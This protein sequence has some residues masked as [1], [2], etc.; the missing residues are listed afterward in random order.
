[1]TFRK[2]LSRVADLLRWGWKP[3]PLPIPREPSRSAV[4][5]KTSS[6]TTDAATIPAGLEVFRPWSLQDIYAEH[7]AR[8]IA[9]ARNH[10]DL[11]ADVQRAADK[12]WVDLALEPIPDRTGL[13]AYLIGWAM[14]AMDT[15]TALGARPALRPAGYSHMVIVFAAVSQVALAHGLLEE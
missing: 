13:V 10:P 7:G 14:G 5:L 4:D 3:P 9:E 15:T 6:P 2:F 11:A 12:I 8:I 1:M